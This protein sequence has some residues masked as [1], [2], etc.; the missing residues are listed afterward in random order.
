MPSRAYSSCSPCR[1]TQ[2]RGQMGKRGEGHGKKEKQGGGKA[3]ADRQRMSY[4]M[5]WV[6]QQSRAEMQ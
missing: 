2:H 3:G 4:A 6:P 1:P 5:R